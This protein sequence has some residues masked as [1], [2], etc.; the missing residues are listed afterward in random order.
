MIN[1]LAI[2]DRNP[3]RNKVNW[4]GD[5]NQICYM[6]LDSAISHTLGCGGCKYTGDEVL[7]NFIV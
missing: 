3:Y 1:L 2:G 4:C 6:D 5:Q 7:K